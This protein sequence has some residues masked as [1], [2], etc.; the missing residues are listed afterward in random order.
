MKKVLHVGCGKKTMETMGS[1]FKDGTWQ[2][3]RFDIDEDLKPD[4]VGTQL[5]MGAVPDE[6]VDAIWSSHN[7]EHVYFHE[8][9]DVLSEFWRVLKDDGFCV[10]TCPDV[11]EACR[12]VAKASLTS[13]LYESPSGPVTALDIFYGHLGSVAHGATYMAHKSGFNVQLLG[14]LLRRAGFFQVTG[15]ERRQFFDL[16]FIAFKSDVSTS[17]AR[18]QFSHYT[19]I[20]LADQS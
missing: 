8:V 1:G 19:D 12:R 9:P 4:I 20:S 10:I 15:R 18:E 3:I 7:I 14:N 2:E 17:Y 11:E 6:S 13:T 5:D 16:W